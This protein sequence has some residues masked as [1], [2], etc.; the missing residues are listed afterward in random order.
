MTAYDSYALRAFE[1]HALDYLL[2][3][4]DRERFRLALDRAREEAGTVEADDIARREA[5]ALASDRRSERG[6]APPSGSSSR[7][8]AACSSC[9]TRDIDW[10]EA[11]G[12]YLRCTWAPRRT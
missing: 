4:F 3:P 5:L 2:K 1:V 10:I 7:P 8:A 6:R 9:R 11:A 12:N